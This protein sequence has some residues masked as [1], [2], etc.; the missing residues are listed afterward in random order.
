M[1]GK[2]YIVRVVTR[3]L[4]LYAEEFITLNYNEHSVTEDMVLSLLTDKPPPETLPLYYMVEEADKVRGPIT[5]RD[6]RS[7][8]LNRKEDEKK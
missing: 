2:T 5:A 7:H 3:E 1:S 8:F 4:L 6:I